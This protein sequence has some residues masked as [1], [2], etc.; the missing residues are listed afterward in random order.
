M[1]SSAPW[2]VTFRRNLK[3]R[4]YSCSQ[5]RDRRSSDSRSSGTNCEKKL[6]QTTRLSSTVTGAVGRP[7]TRR[8]A[9]TVSRVCRS[10]AGGPRPRRPS[11]S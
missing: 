7:C 8:S 6:L 1:L 9:L 4:K 5:R 10:N 2:F 3:H 11:D